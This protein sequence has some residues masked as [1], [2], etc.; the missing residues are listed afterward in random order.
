LNFF[1][2]IIGK[3]RQAVTKAEHNQLT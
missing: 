2:P 3:K 1:F